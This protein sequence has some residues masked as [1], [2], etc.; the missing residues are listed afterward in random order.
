MSDHR[1]DAEP[2]VVGWDVAAALRVRTPAEK[3]EM[4][5]E[6]WRFARR[7]C[8]AGVRRQHPGWDDSAVQQEVARRIAG[9]SG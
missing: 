4:I 6:M 5:C 9:E 8:E 7:L 2:E 3:F 1:P